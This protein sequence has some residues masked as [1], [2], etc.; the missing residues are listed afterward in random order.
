M[1]RR[2]EAVQR[3]A[4]KLTMPSKRSSY[5][6]HRFVHV[7]R[8]G[9][10]VIPADGPRYWLRHVVYHAP[11]RI[12]Y[13]YSGSGPADLALSILADH[14]DEQP[15]ALRRGQ[16]RCWAPHQA[17]QWAFLASMPRRGGEITSDQIAAWLAQ[18]QAERPWQEEEA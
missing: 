10:Q 4:V 15:T 1:P 13:G 3:A 5:Q 9:C 18:W 8:V 11:A 12:N 6:S 2:A 7:D 16:C 14:F 17:F